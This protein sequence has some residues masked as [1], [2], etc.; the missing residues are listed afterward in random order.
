MKRH[1]FVFLAPALVAL[2]L[3]SAAM[4]SETH[5][6]QN[7]RY[8]TVTGERTL[9]GNC[10]FDLPD[11]TLDVHE[12]ATG[13]QQISTDFTT[14]TMVVAVGYPTK[15]ALTSL[16]A[17]GAEVSG[18]TPAHSTPTSASGPDPAP[19]CCEGG[20]YGSGYYKIQWEDVWHWDLTKTYAFLRWTWNGTC[21]DWWDG[22]PDQWHRSETGWRLAGYD[23]GMYFAGGCG[24]IVSATDT[25]FHHGGEVFCSGS[26]VWISIYDAQAYG[27]RWGEFGGGFWYNQTNQ[28]D[29]GPNL[30]WHDWLVRTG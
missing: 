20:A 28:C 3:A 19:P 7:V 26:D 15:A 21:V 1:C 5:G 23:W 12:R 18:L 22:R 27:N 8:E 13:R 6:I 25:V 9:S 11:L 4:A 10:S 29:P 17:E 16:L 30:H 24:V 14:C 2:I